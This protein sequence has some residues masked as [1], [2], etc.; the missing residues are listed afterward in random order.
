MWGPPT[1]SLRVLLGITP[2]KIAVI[3]GRSRSGPPTRWLCQT[4]PMDDQRAVLSSAVTSLDELVARITGVAE[5]MHRRGD[6]SLA[7]DLFEVERSLRM[8]HRRLGVVTRRLR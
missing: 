2:C 6:E 5:E 3:S 4:R 1:G 8:A 7:A